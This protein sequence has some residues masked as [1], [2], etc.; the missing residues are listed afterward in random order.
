[1]RRAVGAHEGGFEVERERREVMPERVVE[2]AGDAEAFREAAAVGNEILHR[3]KLRARPQ[4]AVEK[5]ER[6]EGQ[7]LKS[8][9]RRR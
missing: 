6:E 8:E 2:L 5:L 7:D 1:M 9:I 4:L 3:P